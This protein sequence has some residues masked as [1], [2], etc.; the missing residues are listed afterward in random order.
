MSQ[1]TIF[2]CERPG[3]GRRS[4]A[5]RGYGS[6]Y[7]VGW[8][9]LDIRLFEATAE[10]MRSSPWSRSNDGSSHRFD[11]RLVVQLC[12]DCASEIANVFDRGVKK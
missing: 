7:P 10:K 6:D 1:L 11:T 9:V 3:C 8:G 12:A 4:E 5:V 2:E